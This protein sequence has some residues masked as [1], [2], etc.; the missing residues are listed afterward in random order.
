MNTEH[1]KITKQHTAHLILLSI[2]LFFS[3]TSTCWSNATTTV[4]HTMAR[5]YLNPYTEKFKTLEDKI[6]E[7]GYAL[8]INPT[9]YG[10]RQLATLNQAK[11]DLLQEI[12]NAKIVFDIFARNEILHG[13][14]PSNIVNLNALEHHLYVV[15]GPRSKERGTYLDSYL[16]K[17]V[18]KDAQLSLGRLKWAKTLGTVKTDIG[19]LERTKT[20]VKEFH[21]NRELCT[22]VTQHLEEIKQLEE[23]VLSFWREEHHAEVNQFAPYMHNSMFNIAASITKSLEHL[24]KKNGG[25]QTQEKIDALDRSSS[26]LTLSDTQSFMQNGVMMALGMGYLQNGWGTIK[27]QFANLQATF[28]HLPSYRMVFLPAVWATT[29]FLANKLVEQSIKKRFDDK[30]HDIIL[31]LNFHHQIKPQKKGTH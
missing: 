17:H 25:T 13:E 3:P 2:L 30:I 11:Q 4:A 7:T 14:Q 16:L 22:K 26:F 27:N 10:H 1:S 31:L 19:E 21:D 15:C 23:L 28:S 6:R 5:Q 29:M 12:T 8:Q 9:S 20:I 24:R 18:A